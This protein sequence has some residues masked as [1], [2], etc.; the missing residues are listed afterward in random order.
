MPC[1]CECCRRFRES[2]IADALRMAEALPENGELEALRKVAT[3]ARRHVQTV[4]GSLERVSSHIAL[5]DALEE[6]E[7]VL[8]AK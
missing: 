5:Y 7:K 4:Y 6:W 2:R 3:A 8:K 1:Q